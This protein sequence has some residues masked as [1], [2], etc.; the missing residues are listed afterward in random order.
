MAKSVL[1]RWGDSTACPICLI[2][3]MVLWAVYD[4]RCPG[5]NKW[6][7]PT[8]IFPYWAISCT[9]MCLLFYKVSFIA[10]RF[11]LVMESRGHLAYCS[12]SARALPTWKGLHD[13]KTWIHDKHCS[14]YCL[15][16]L[17][18]NCELGISSPSENLTIILCSTDRG[19]SCS[20][21]S[22]TDAARD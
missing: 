12:C 11:S 19:T 6:A 2:V 4:K 10:S 7:L 8:L 20:L 9:V 5:E 1:Y 18:K 16:S 14:P 17:I 13:S 15:R 21:D 3:S 22:F